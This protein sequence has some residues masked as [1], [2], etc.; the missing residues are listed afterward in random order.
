MSNVAPSTLRR[1]VA[2]FQGSRYRWNNFKAV[3]ETARQFRIPVEEVVAAMQA[4]PGAAKPAE[5]KL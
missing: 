2:L 4:A 1:S 5:Q 3:R